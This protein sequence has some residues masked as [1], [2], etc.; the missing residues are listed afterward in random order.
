MV[1]P[2]AASFVERLPTWALGLPVALLLALGLW[3]GLR[4]ARAL[5]ARGPARARRLGA[6]GRRRALAL[7]ARAGYRVTAVEV[8]RRGWLTVDGQRVAFE[9]RADAWVERGGRGWVAEFKGGPSAANP[10]ARDTR[11]Q[12]LEYVHVFGVRG[13]LLVDAVRGRIHCVEFG[14]G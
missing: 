9:V 14:P 13:L 7:L 12:L 5:G 11:R 8:A 10:A 3:L 2:F 1:L 4:L 6:A